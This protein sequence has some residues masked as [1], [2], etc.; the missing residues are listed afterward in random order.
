MKTYKH[1]SCEERTLIQ[2]SFEQGCK[3]RAIAR[4][5][6]RAPSSISRELRRNGWRAPEPAAKKGPGR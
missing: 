2:L 1:L 5:L 3:L 4:S 6:H